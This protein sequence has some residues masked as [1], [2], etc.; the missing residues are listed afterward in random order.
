[1]KK[2]AFFTALLMFALISG[3]FGQNSMTFTFTAVNGPEYFRLESIRV[4]NMTCSCD[5]MLI[6]P[7]TVLVIN[8]LG[9]LNAITGTPGFTLGQNYPNPVAVETTL[10]LSVPDKDPVR[11][12]IMDAAGRQLYTNRFNLDQGTHSFPY[13]TPGSG[14]YLFSATW[15]GESRTVRILAA[16]DRQG[17]VQ[18]LKYKGKNGS[19]GWMKSNEPI[20]EFQ[21][22]LGDELLL[23]GY[24]EGRESGFD[25][26]PEG[27]MDYVFRFETNVPCPDLDSLLY[28][29]Q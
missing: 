18:S 3:L 19:Q 28:D 14:L 23:T 9:V 22:T 29:G 17:S 11:I 16:G 15:N 1:M 5:T 10:I 13:T 12:S 25:D 24:G 27:D 2:N 26:S 7:D 21:F 20:A 4:R 6:Y 8:Y